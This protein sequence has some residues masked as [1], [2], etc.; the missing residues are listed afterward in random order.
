MKPFTCLG[1]G[2]LIFAAPVLFAQN[3][4]P[5]PWE[6]DWHHHE[7]G[8]DD[9]ESPTAVTDGNPQ[10]NTGQAAATVAMDFAILAPEAVVE[11][12]APGET[13][14]DGTPA[15]ATA[16]G[17]AGAGMANALDIDVGYG[18]S[19]VG[20]VDVDYYTVSLP[21]SRKWSDRGTLKVT[22]PVS[23]TNMRD[24]LFNMDG[25]T[26]DARV[27]GGGVNVGYVY[28]PFIKADGKPYRWKVT[29]SAGLFMRDSSDLDQGSWV[30]N[31]GFSSSFAYRLSEH[32]VINVGNSVSFAWNS[33]YKDYPDPL[34]DEQQVTINGVQMFYLAGRW[35]YYGYVMDTRFLKDALVDNFQSY[36][37]GFGFKLTRNRT[38]KV[39]LLYEDGDNYESL[40]GTVGT[41]W[42][43]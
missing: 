19:T 39:T 23:I 8:F 34:R 3:D 16:G 35:T 38:L 21:Y 2:V 11:E 7:P 42:K 10:S 13:G 17:G 27:Y 31:L 29:P 20:N 25:S 36:A 18:T 24:V 6:E 1:L 15:E 9:P 30:Y 33:G 37:L 26:G 28:K 5:P 22:V 43:F 4:P 14:A 32:W 40:R 41:S 12:F